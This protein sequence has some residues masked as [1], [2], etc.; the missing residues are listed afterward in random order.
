MLT[1]GKTASTCEPIVYALKKHQLATIVGQTTAGAMLSAAFF[2][3]YG[4]YYL[5]L[6]IADYYTS[7]GKR[8]DQVGVEPDIPVE[9]E[10]A[11]DVAKQLLAVPD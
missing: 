2:Q 9:A 11:L 5:F 4:K 1:S 8:L 7:D 6:P 10:S 3:V